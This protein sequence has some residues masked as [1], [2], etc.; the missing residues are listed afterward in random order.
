MLRMNCALGIETRQ[1]H[2][3]ANSSIIQNFSLSLHPVAVLRRNARRTQEWKLANN[4]SVELLR[5]AAER[6]GMLSSCCSWLL[7]ACLSFSIHQRAGTNQTRRQRLPEVSTIRY[8]WCCRRRQ[9]T[10]VPTKKFPG[11]SSKFAADGIFSLA[12]IN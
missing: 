3:Q 5:N 11:F 1:R 7:L 6:L 2:V 12:S 10:I 4:S 8:A 9:V